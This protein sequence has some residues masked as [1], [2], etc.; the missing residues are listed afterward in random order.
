MGTN[1]P[2]GDKQKEHTWLSV[3]QQSFP[4]HDVRGRVYD[5]EG[6]LKIRETTF[7]HQENRLNNYVST[8]KDA[9]I[10]KE[11]TSKHAT[12]TRVR[13]CISESPRGPCQATTQKRRLIKVFH[14]LVSC[15]CNGSPRRVTKIN[16]VTNRPR[17]TNQKQ[18]STLVR[19][20]TIYN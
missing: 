5:R 11:R 4:E 16:S 20:L 6:A 1:I 13:R 14:V 10:P 19:G 12:N 9:Y 17:R 18:Y 8:F 7:K 3:Q 2:Q 15:S